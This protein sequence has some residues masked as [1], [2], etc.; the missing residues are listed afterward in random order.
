MRKNKRRV[1]SKFLWKKPITASQRNRLLLAGF[2]YRANPAP[3]KIINCVILWLS[4]LKNRNFCPLKIL[5]DWQTD[6]PTDQPKEWLMTYQWTRRDTWSYLKTA[7][8]DNQNA[9]NKNM[10]NF[11]PPSRVRDVSKQTSMPCETFQYQEPGCSIFGQQWTQIVKE[12]G[13]IC[14]TLIQAPTIWFKSNS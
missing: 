4:I 5:Y 8:H 14:Y 2:Y 12:E 11:T 13:K 1:F 10:H 3:R 9:W 6:G 7:R